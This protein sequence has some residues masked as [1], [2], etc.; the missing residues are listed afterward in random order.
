MCERRM[1]K[2]EK[3]LCWKHDSYIGHTSKIKKIISIEPIIN[4]VV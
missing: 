2:G 3:S 4:I 1:V